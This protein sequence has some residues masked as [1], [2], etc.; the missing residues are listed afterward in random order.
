MSA[1][2]PAPTEAPAPAPTEAPEALGEAPTSAPEV[3]AGAPGPEGERSGAGRPGRWMGVSQG[4]SQTP[5]PTGSSSAA[6]EG[7]SAPGDPI[8]LFVMRPQDG[9]VTVGECGA[10]APGGEE[11]GRRYRASPKPR[12]SPLSCRWQ[13]HLLGPRG[14][15]QPLET[16]CG[17]VVQGQVGGPEQ[18]G[19]AAPAAARQLRSDQQGGAR[20]RRVTGTHREGTWRA[21][22]RPRGTERQGHCE[23]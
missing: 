12:R 13:H 9:E 18:Q 2:A 17:Q 7:P 21:P 6:P 1:P 10:A 5:L 4:R 20:G 16:T 23:T 19:G 14:R 11:R 3:E 22:G 8:G 15:S